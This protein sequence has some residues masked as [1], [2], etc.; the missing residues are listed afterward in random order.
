MLKCAWTDG[1]TLHV[2]KWAEA[3]TNLRGGETLASIT[4]G[5]CALEGEVVIAKYKVGKGEVI[6]CGAL[7]E[8]PDID[9]LLAIA[10]EDAGVTPYKTMGMLS[11]VPREGEGGEGLV[12]CETAHAPASIELDAPMTDLLTGKEFSGTLEVEPYG[13]YVLK[14]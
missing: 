4:G 1:E 8:D 9:R 11:V 13:V 2:R 7:L 3:Y 14:K 6:L 5:H 10:Y 12:L